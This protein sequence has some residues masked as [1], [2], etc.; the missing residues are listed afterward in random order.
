ME[1]DK[2]PTLPYATRII[3]MVLAKTIPENGPRT[4]KDDIGASTVP[5]IAI[6]EGE[7]QKVSRTPFPFSLMQLITA[8]NHQRPGTPATQFQPL[9]TGTASS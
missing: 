6:T 1:K 5:G 3:Q 8:C 9:Q 7:A 2:M 4:R